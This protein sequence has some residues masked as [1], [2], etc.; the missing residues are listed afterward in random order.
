[1][2]CT[3]KLHRGTSLYWCLQTKPKNDLID[4]MLLGQTHHQKPN[5]VYGSTDITLLMYTTEFELVLWMADLIHFYS[6]LHIFSF[7]RTHLP[8][9]VVTQY[10]VYCVKWTWITVLINHHGFQSP[11]CICIRYVFTWII[12]TL[13]LECV[14]P[15]HLKY[16]KSNTMPY[17]ARPRVPHLLVICEEWCQI[18]VG[19]GIHSIGWFHSTKPWNIMSM[20]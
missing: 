17:F 20:M 8:T 16:S 10:D 14:K 12:N 2:E 4:N 13:E 6:I 3:I 1:M 7:S 18:A 19:I 9:C 11:L 15:V 5:L